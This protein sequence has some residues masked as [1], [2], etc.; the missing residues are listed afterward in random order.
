MSLQIQMLGTGSAFAKTF[1]NTSA[2]IRSNGMNVL[3]DCGAT[4]PKSLYD[5]QMQPDQIDGIIITHIHADHVGGLEEMAFRLLYES[6]QKKTKLF[7]T[8]A[9]AD[10]LWENTLKGGMYN[11]E[12]GYHS[13]EDYFDVN[14]IEEQVPI[15]IGPGLT[16]EF[17]PTLHIHLKPN[18][19]LFINDRIFYSADIRFSKD[20]LL[21]EVV[22][23][24][25]C[26]TI[27]HDCQL[28]GQGFIHATLDELL[29]LP[30]HIQ[31]RIYLMHYADNMSDFI[32]KTGSMKFIFQHEV[33]EFPS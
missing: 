19:S 2:L 6:N 29:T 11:P 7:L 4:T 22:G 18:Y 20:L 13:L 15:E 3:I 31:Q 9:I 5:I 12:E 1:Y 25:N 26:H 27:F 28:S 23:I 16:I 10:I 30:E 24:R 14:L 17:L 21:H 33:I 32:G 8:M